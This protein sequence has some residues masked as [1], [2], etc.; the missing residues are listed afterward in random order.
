MVSS[1]P[2]RW[3]YISVVSSGISMLACGGTVASEQESA[4]STPAGA[5]E[6]GA[7]DTVPTARPNPDGAA[8]TIRC[9]TLT[10]TATQVCGGH[11]DGHTEC[12]ERG[13]EPIAGKSPWPWPSVLLYCDGDDDC[14][15]GTRCIMMVGEIFSASCLPETG[16]CTRH[17]DHLCSTDSDCHTCPN[18]GGPDRKYTC[19]PKMF[20]SLK[21]LR[22]CS[23]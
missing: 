13:S 19:R 9:G 23:P 3:I 20:S 21:D 10:C 8:G 6:A 22:A 4:D 18:P 2:V 14:P 16:S 12:Y 15:G 17:T 11:P 7:T 1:R 5:E